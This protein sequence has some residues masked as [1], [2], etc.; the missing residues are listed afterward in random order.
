MALP[1]PHIVYLY[2]D[3]PYLPPPSAQRER[4]RALLDELLAELRAQPRM[5]I[6]EV[7]P[8]VAALAGQQVRGPYARTLAVGAAGRRVAELLHAH[9]GWFPAIVELPLTRVEETDG[10][11]RVVARGA[12][13]IAR[14]AA[15]AGPLAIVDDTVY[16]G[17]TLGWLLNRLPPAVE[18]DLFCLQGVASTLATLRGRGR[19]HAGIELA[20]ER[21]RDLTV[22]KASHLFEPGAIHTTRGDLAFYERREWMDAW[23]AD[24]S[25][26]IV[27][28]CERLRHLLPSG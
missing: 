22:I 6:L 14:L 21:E 4:W 26:T 16:A 3:L 27:A 10:S 1:T 18:A 12:V 28:L 17:Q 2:N 13:D 25:A 9:T 24:A 11:Y 19:V 7:E 5:R 8:L 23:F 15:D 20:G